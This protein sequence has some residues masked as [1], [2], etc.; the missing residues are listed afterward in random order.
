MGLVEEVKVWA[1]ICYLTHILR[2][3]FYEKANTRP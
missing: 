2:G 1:Q 3:I